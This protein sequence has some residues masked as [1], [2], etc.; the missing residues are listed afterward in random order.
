MDIKEEKTELE[1]AL[2]K[3]EMV[4]GILEVLADGYGFIRS[5]NYLSSSDDVYVSSSQI[6]RFKR[7]MDY[8]WKLWKNT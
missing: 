1:E 4:T 6:R 5:E 2:E 8:R 3:G 7:K